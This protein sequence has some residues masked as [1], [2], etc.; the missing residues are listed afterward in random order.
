MN[1]GSFF[2]VLQVLISAYSY[3]QVNIKFKNPYKF[4]DDIGQI[5]SSNGQLAAFFYSA[6]GDYD[7]SLK[8]W[9]EIVGV[10]NPAKDK[11]LQFIS[12]NQYRLTNAI[13][14]IVEKAKKTEYVILNEAHHRP[15]HRVFALKVLKELFN[16]GYRNLGVETLTGKGKYYDD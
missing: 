1:L 11:V 6:I 9:D 16:L 15:D 12:K 4:S 13:P 14:I 2:L 5:T 3:S 8:V 7:T 10:S